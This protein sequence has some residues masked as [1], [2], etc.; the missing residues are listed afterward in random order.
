MK[1]MEILSPLWETMKGILPLT[2]IMA[3]F[4]IIILR[5]SI[6]N[7]KEFGIGIILVVIGLHLFLKGTNMSLIPLGDSVEETCMF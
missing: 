5:K 2:V 7:V 3:I 4:Q 6:E 1:I